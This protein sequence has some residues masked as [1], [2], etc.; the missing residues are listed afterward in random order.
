MCP[1]F[2]VTIALLDPG[3]KA[4]AHGSS[5][6]ATAVDENGGEEEERFAGPVDVPDPRGVCAFVCVDV[7]QAASESRSAGNIKYRRN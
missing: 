1:G 4:S 6:V 7:P 5:N 2:S 3:R